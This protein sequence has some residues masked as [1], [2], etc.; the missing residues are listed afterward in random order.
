MADQ[1]Y[2]LYAQGRDL[3]RLVAI[4]GE[5]SLGADDRRR[6]AFAEQ[7]ERRF[8]HQGAAGRPIEVTLDLAWALLADFPATELKRVSRAHIERYKP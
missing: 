1:L 2:A 8:V 5:A 7:F 3:R 6:L 4:I